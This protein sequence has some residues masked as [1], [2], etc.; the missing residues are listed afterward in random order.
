LTPDTSGVLQVCLITC[1]RLPELDPDDRL[2]LDPLT[3]LGCDVTAA[4]WDDA[5]VDWDRFDVSVLRSTWDYTDRREEFVRWASS[6]PRLLNPADVVAWNTNKRYL[7]DLDRAGVPVI[8]TTWISDGTNEHLPTTGEYVI[9]PAVGAGSLDAQR[10]NFEDAADRSRA[11]EHVRRLVDRTQTVMVQPYASGIEST[12]ETGVIF[13]D[14]EFSH[15]I[16]K[17][18]MLGAVVLDEV[19]G[20]YREEAIE[21]RTATTDELDLA[22]AAL[23]AASEILQLEGPLLYARIDM[24]R[25]ENGRPT[26]M[27]LELT[28]P[29]LFMATT[30]GSEGRF[31]SAIANRA[32]QRGRA[33]APAQRARPQQERVVS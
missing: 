7:D 20:L 10:F 30:P 1:A 29:S 14:G 2:T 25:G 23:A 6:V 11:E 9:K 26:L 21:S 4:V 15:A 32:K 5:G 22:Q 24:V 13:V 28:E 33:R 16:R 31:A 27:E 8:P 19:D 3:L 12:G 17:G 18:P